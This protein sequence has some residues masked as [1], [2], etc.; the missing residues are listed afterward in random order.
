MAID[1]Y[2]VGDGIWMQTGHLHDPVP[3]PDI[4]DRRP[5][6]KPDDRLGVDPGERGEGLDRVGTAYA[7][8]LNL[9][10]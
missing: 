5:I 3:S 6:L 7:G 8:G 4:E 10:S 2:P 1:P 9:R